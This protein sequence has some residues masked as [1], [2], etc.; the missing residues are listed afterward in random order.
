MDLGER[1]D[2]VLLS[3]EEASRLVTALRAELLRQY[4]AHPIVS[5]A[6]R[7]VANLNDILNATA[8]RLALLRWPPGNSRAD[9]DVDRLIG[10]VDQAGLL[11]RVLQRYVRA[12]QLGSPRQSSDGEAA[13]SGPEDL[14]LKRELEETARTPPRVLIIPEPG[15]DGSPIGVSLERSGYSVTIAASAEDGLERLRSGDRFDNVVCDTSILQPDAAKFVAAVASAAP[16]V[17][18]YLL[19]RL[20]TGPERSRELR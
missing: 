1:Y 18:L 12:A 6:A 16:T 11:V 19:T 13:A 8:L 20:E 2:G 17:K 10:L 4:R 14:D 3:P 5:L 7:A 15:T 9:S